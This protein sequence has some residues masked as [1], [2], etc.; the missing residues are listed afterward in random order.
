MYD[1]F[2]LFRIWQCLSC[3]RDYTFDTMTDDEQEHKLRELNEW[4]KC[5]YC[6]SE[7][8]I[9]LQMQLDLEV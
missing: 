7:S 9:E 1:V 4:T 5:E 2:P 6:S 8:E 3:G